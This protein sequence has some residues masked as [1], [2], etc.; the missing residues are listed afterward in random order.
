M[1]QILVD[2]QVAATIANGKTVEIELAPGRHGVIARHG[3]LSSLPVEIEAGHEGIHH[4]HVGSNWMHR[5]P[6]KFALAL[7]LLPVVAALLLGFVASA[8]IADP[9]GAGWVILTMETL[10]LPAFVSLIVMILWRHQPTPLPRGH[11]DPQ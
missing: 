11:R 7:M 2:G 5:R 1:Y 3:F 9:I 8:R 6:L 10:L 4:L